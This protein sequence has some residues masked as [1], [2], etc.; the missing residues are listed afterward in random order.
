MIDKTIEFFCALKEKI[1]DA[2]LLFITKEK[3]S[4]SF[5]LKKH[6]K[7]EDF[8][9]LTVLHHNV[10]NYLRSANVGI[11]FR[12]KSIINEVCS[13]VKFAEYLA[14]GIPVILTEGIGDTAEIVKSNKVGVI[15][16]FESRKNIESAIEQL[17]EL[18][19]EKPEFLKQR[20]KKVAEKYFSWEKYLD[21]YSNVYQELSN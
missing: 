10:S 20:C 21:K 3:E 12:E 1:K 8:T 11:L 16:N 13:P 9:V 17:I 2:H 7:K 6:L 15:I 14:S 4:V 5:N 18:S 19:L